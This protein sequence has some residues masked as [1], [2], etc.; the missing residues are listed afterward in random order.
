MR[1]LL[2]AT[3]LMTAA[4]AQAGE[5]AVRG[6]PSYCLPLY[7]QYKDTH[8]RKAEARLLRQCGSWYATVKARE[9]ERQQSSGC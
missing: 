2:I 8:S 3:L 7:Q 6:T 4:G 1:L 5:Q 9:S